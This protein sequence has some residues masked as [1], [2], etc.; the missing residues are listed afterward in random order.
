MLTDNLTESIKKM[1]QLNIV[2]NAAMDVEKKAKNDADFSVLVDD[3][4]NSVKKIQKAIT[5]MDYSITSK[6]LQYLEE[7]V[8]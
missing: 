4:A 8:E 3:F 7:G 6:T 2:E 1:K 5:V